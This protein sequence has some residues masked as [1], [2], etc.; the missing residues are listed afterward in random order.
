LDDEQ[1]YAALP[2]L[3]SR[4]CA[5]Q[6]RELFQRLDGV[7]L[8]SM[9]G[10]AVVAIIYWPLRPP[11]HLLGWVGF[12][13]LV[14]GARL[15]L[16][17]AWNADPERNA[18]ARTWAGRF[19]FLTG[20]SGVFWGSAAWLLVAADAP[21]QNALLHFVIAAGVA[22]S[23]VNFALRWQT[24][25][26]LS[27]PALSPF[28]Y[29]F[30]TLDAPMAAQTAVMIGIFGVVMLAMSL[31]L[32]RQHDY[33]IRQQLQYEH[34]ALYFR[35]QQ[36][37]FRS[38]VESTRA[39]I[40]EGRPGSFEFSY[41]SPEVEKLLGY[42]AS[43][44]LN[45]AGFWVE[46][47]HPEDRAWAPAHCEALTRKLQDHAFDY[48]M[49]AADGRVVWL[50]DV[51]NVISHNGK[52]QKVVGVMIDITEIKKSEHILKS[53][54]GMRQ[55]MVELSRKFIR[56]SKPDVD[57]ALS[58]MLEQIG[59]WC[60]V[61]RAYVIRFTPNHAEYSNTHEWVAP[62][63]EPAIH[64]LQRM[65]ASTAPNLIAHLKQHKCVLLT[66]IEALDDE[67]A[68]EKDIF[69]EQGIRSL[70]N[71]PIFSDGVLIGLVGCDSV[72]RQHAWSQ[73]EASLM[74]VLGDLL[75][76]ALARTGTDGAL[77]E[78]EAL[79]ASAETLAGMGS[80]EWLIEDDTLVVSPEWRK[81]TGCYCEALRSGDLLQMVHQKDTSTVQAALEATLVTGCSFDVE[82]RLV[83]PDDGHQRWVKAHALLMQQEGRPY[84][85]RGFLQ[86]ISERRRAQ[87]KLYELA[88]YDR[89]TG[90]PNR[91][92]ASD[93][94]GHALRRMRRRD[95]RL[96][97]FF[98]D[99][100]NFKKVNDTLGHEAGDRVLVES[101][102]RLRNA[103]REEDAVARIGGD[104]FVVTVEGF[105]EVAELRQIAEK[106][107]AGFRSAM[108]V[109]DREFMLTASIGI[110]VFPQDG[111]SVDGL[112]R[113]ADTAMYH[114][115]HGGGDASEFF[116]RDM[117]EEVERQHALEEAM[118]GTLERGEMM[119]Y[120]QPVIDLA[121]GRIVG[122]EALLRWQHPL[123]GNVGPDEFIPVA[124]HSGQVKELGEFVLR[125]SLAM[126]SEFR[127]R[128]DEDFHVSINVS[129]HQFRDRV[130]ADTVIATLRHHELPGNALEIEI[131]E[132]VLLS[133]IENVHETLS[134]LQSVG[135]GVAMDDFGTGYA[136][137]SYLRDYP[138]S[139][140]KIDRSFVMYMDQEPRSR[141]LVVSAIRLAQSLGMK[142]IAEGIET[143]RQLRL[144]REEG[145]QL[146][147]GYLF[148][149]A[150]DAEA[151]DGLV[152]GEIELSLK[153]TAGDI[154]EVR[155]AG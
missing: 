103:L 62:G 117:N 105:A 145:C 4:I 119:V 58:E 140:L 113:S 91:V 61:D 16:K 101:A 126:A 25:W 80:W 87:E 66:D 47:M 75:G 54:S 89:L 60:E 64:K 138:F 3:E 52:V 72:T 144:L 108:V 153:E 20:M 29:R 31:R 56:S 59:R 141:E 93:R 147:Q 127:K 121:R 37:R 18:R 124:E 23:A 10:V 73:E 11:G 38:L 19:D 130:F 46:H 71:L 86:D 149:P 122:A 76:E 109:N 116:T 44:W 152:R 143:T 96:A 42:P 85:L 36:Q 39:I 100:D 63:I 48:R 17:R 7:L 120:Y 22:T 132:G 27:V 70:I 146:G 111:D 9:V 15:W 92:L 102:K 67:W 135:V 90:L 97:V 2:E 65:P 28:V 155:A 34:D 51:V 139:S 21:Q 74:Q 8:S 55:L 88:H 33:G 49:I 12:Y 123:L 1:Q 45:D 40:W 99:L 43:D 24:A 114:A 35:A 112:M 107:L 131:T 125:E 98:M 104:E 68:A 133:G 82:Y 106:I 77:R 128:I 150:V 5:E 57:D 148:S 53:M 32:A 129:P 151:F 50:R 154:D 26:L 83:R 137:L 134:L 81:V 142:V 95:K 94:L 69:R 78:S 136:S 13:V 14:T 115:K 30:S 79:R 6:N 110:A 84:K 118:R 41:V